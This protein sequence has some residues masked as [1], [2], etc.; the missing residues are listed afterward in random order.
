[1]GVVTDARAAVSFHSTLK[2]LEH[3]EAEVAEQIQRAIAHSFTSAGFQETG[4]YRLVDREGNNFLLDLYS[5]GRETWLSDAQGLETLLPLL[6]SRPWQDLVR[7]EHFHTH[8]NLGPMSWSLSGADISS[9]LRIQKMIATTLGIN[10]PYVENVV[11]T[12]SAFGTAPGNVT[13]VAITPGEVSQARSAIASKLVRERQERRIKIPLPPKIFGPPRPD[14]DG[15]YPFGNHDRRQAIEKTIQI[16]MDVE[17]RGKSYQQITLGRQQ[18]LQE[19]P[20]LYFLPNSDF[21]PKNAASDYY[22][23]ALALGMRGIVPNW[24]KMIVD[25][26]FNEIL[27]QST[28]LAKPKPSQLMIYQNS[29]NGRITKISVYL[30][31]G[32][33]GIWRALSRINGTGD[34]AFA[35]DWDDVALSD[36]DRVFF[37][38]LP[39]LEVIEKLRRD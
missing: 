9:V 22:A 37:Y 28:W 29:Q 14:Q 17:L 19:L 2:L 36:G 26:H 23:I 4:F 32:K 18:R 20:F 24:L 13:R 30:G 35:H 8:P 21:N 1:M 10:V 5:S 27:Q 25:L 11:H 16:A 12:M 15:A 6:Q 38:E 34:V 39:S 3:F 33:N 7:I 31:T